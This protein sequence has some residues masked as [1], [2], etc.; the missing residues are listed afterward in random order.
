[1]VTKVEKII[2][3]R[4]G[5]NLSLVNNGQ[6][7][8]KILNLVIDKCFK[9]VYNKIYKERGDKMGKKKTIEEI[10]QAF[11]KEGYI[12]L[13]T[14]YI[15]AHNKLDYIC[16]K[17]HRHSITWSKFNTGRRCPKCSGQIMTFE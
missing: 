5:Q 12:L 15:N 4:Y 2:E 3:M 7:A 14:E 6:S 10:K 11:E 9:M 8:G 16:P 17:G 1:M 13:S